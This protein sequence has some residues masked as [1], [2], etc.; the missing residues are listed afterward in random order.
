MEIVPQ[1]GGPAALRLRFGLS[2]GP[3]AGQYAALRVATPEGVSG[4]SRLSFEARA[5]RPM[6]ISVQ[7][8]TERGRWQRSIYLD[9][10]SQP[11]TIFFDEFTP[12]GETDTYS[13][14][15]SDVRNILFVVDTVNTKP[16][17]SGRLWIS[18]PTLEQ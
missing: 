3:P 4:S 17:A 8:Q 9:S 16:G 12:V 11:H 1:L 14:P 18:S 5:E 6:R 13:A 10:V 15:L 7:L 2:T